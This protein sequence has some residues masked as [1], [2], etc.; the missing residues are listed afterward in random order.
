MLCHPCV[1]RDATEGP[2]AR[3]VPVTQAVTASASAS[4]AGIVRAA[5][6]RDRAES[7]VPEAD[8]LLAQRLLATL[9]RLGTSVHEALVARV[10]QVI[11]E[12]MDILVLV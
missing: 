11:V 8:R 9:G 5:E 10:D 6:K 4:R 3:G 2:V 1:M 7:G 12:N